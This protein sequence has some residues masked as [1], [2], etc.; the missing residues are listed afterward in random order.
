MWADLE[1]EYGDRV[2]FFLVDRETEEGGEFIRE[3][4]LPI[5]QPGFVV[6]DAS[7]EVTYAALGPTRPDGVREL[8]ESVVP[9]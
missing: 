1:R 3:H 5:G 7:G 9:Q 4:G 6:Y 2:E 8:V